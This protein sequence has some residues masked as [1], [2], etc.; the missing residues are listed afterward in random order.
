MEKII[1]SDEYSVGVK[2]LDEQH[3]KI[4]KLINTLIDHHNDDVKSDTIS[5]VL[6][7]MVKY[8]QQHLDYEEQLLEKHEYPKLMQHAAIHVEYLEQVASFSFDIMAQDN[9]IPTNLL[10]FLHEWWVRHILYEDM[11]YRPFFKLKGVN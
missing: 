5:E 11:K 7:E 8:A 9:S 2:S 3:Q 1:W 6:Q 10:E 4:I